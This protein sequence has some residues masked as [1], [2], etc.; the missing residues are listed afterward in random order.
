[1]STF[2]AVAPPR[3]R[4]D[5]IASCA[6]QVDTVVAEAALAFT[7]RLARRNTHTPSMQRTIGGEI[8]G[9]AISHS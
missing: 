2:E 1:M 8:S 3:A 7:D 9:G 6:T 4:T 5:H